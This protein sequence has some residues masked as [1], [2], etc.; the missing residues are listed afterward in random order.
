MLFYPAK[1]G[2]DTQAAMVLRDGATFPDGITP[3]FPR[4][5]GVVNVANSFW[6]KDVR[7]VGARV[8]G[9]SA[10]VGTQ[11]RGAF[12]SGTATLQTTAQTLAALIADLRTHGLIG[13]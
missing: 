9:W 1:A 13:V 8:T 2:T 3:V 7:V 6:C 4:G 12:N 11:T 10:P 5:Y